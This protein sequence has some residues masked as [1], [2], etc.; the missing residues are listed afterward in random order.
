MI[1][2]IYFLIFGYS[3]LFIVAIA[4]Y[5]RYKSPKYKA[6]SWAEGNRQVLRLVGSFIKKNIAPILYKILLKIKQWGEQLSR[7]F[8]VWW[9]VHSLSKENDNSLFL[10]EKEYSELIRLLKESLLEF[11]KLGC[12][13]KDD[14]L[15][16][17]LRFDI[18]AIGLISKYRD[19]ENNILKEILCTIIVNYYM[20]T[21]NKY[22]CVFVPVASPIRVQIAIPLS[23]Y[24]NYLLQKETQST[25]DEI[26]NTSS[27]L[28][29]EE[30]DLD[31]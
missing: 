13:Y 21:R 18:H 10:S 30:I 3:Y 17:I 12:I 27:D 20:E 4:G 6:D 26:K 31:E 2:A 1:I 15:K 24:G 5:I 28:L 22:V 29:E 19:I 14:F 16:G 7:K 8:S 9:Q 23:E 11:P 25:A